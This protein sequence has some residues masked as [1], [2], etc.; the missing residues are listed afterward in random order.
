[1]IPMDIEIGVKVYG[2]PDGSSVEVSIDGEDDGADVRLWV[3]LVERSEVERTLMLT[4]IAE[5]QSPHLATTEDSPMKDE[6]RAK[7]VGFLLDLG[8][9]RA[10]SGSSS[11]II[12]GGEY[13]S[14]RTPFFA[15]YPRFVPD[16]IWDRRWEDFQKYVQF[17]AVSSPVPDRP[18][19]PWLGLVYEL[20]AKQMVDRTATHASYARAATAGQA[21]G[22]KQRHTASGTSPEDLM[23][24]ILAE[25]MILPQRDQASWEE[26]H[27]ERGSFVLP[28][29]EEV[30]LMRALGEPNPIL[31]PVSALKEWLLAQ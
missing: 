21:P 6:W 4:V 5:G 2:W 20:S 30:V 1:M 15:A 11:L 10:R 26:S 13:S 12:E 17:D 25:E 29:E 22:F 23:R 18:A 7:L 24:K 8:V 28:T 19:A 16:E 14:S 31:W 27:T 3:K 9:K